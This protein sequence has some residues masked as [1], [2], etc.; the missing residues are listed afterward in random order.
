MQ[1]RE[2]YIMAVK[3][4]RDTGHEEDS[5][6]DAETRGVCGVMWRGSLSWRHVGDACGCSRS[7]EAK[8]FGSVAW[9]QVR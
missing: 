6:G 4:R 7:Y 5:P 9:R 1:S 3:E 2:D 8:R